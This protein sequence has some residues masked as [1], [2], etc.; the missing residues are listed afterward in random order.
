MKLHY[1]QSA[2][3]PNIF[4]IRVLSQQ[5]KWETVTLAPFLPHKEKKLQKVKPCL[6]KLNEL[7]I[8]DTNTEKNFCMNKIY[9]RT[10][11]VNFSMLVIHSKM[12]R[13]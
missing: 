7:Q 2:T 10:N 5:K 4:L 11:K 13:L 8:N 6:N 1:L 3:Y 9:P 12:T